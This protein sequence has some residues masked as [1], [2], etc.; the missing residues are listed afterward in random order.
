MHHNF[1]VLDKLSNICSLKDDVLGCVRVTRILAGPQ[2]G[3]VVLVN[4]SRA[5]LLVPQLIQEGPQVD[6]LTAHLRSTQELRVEG[7]EGDLGK[8]LRSV[9]HSVV[10]D[11][12]IVPIRRR[13]SGRVPSKVGINTTGEHNVAPTE[14]KATAF[15]F[16]DVAENALESSHMDSRVVMAVARELRN[17]V[18]QV[19][20]S[21][22]GRVEEFANVGP[23]RVCNS[24][25]IF[26]QATLDREIEAFG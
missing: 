13:E 12:A 8:F 15:G 23:V 20:A 5:M 7:R 14:D 2:S 24:I 17:R 16:G 22:D 6:N 26:T 10:A 25:L 18:S 3:V 1:L 21:A 9:G 11:F 4:A 19:R